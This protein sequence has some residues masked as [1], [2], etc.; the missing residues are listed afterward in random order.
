MSNSMSNDINTLIATS[1]LNIMSN[2]INTLIVMFVCDGYL[3]GLLTG[4]PKY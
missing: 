3:L 4:L 2:D 1:M